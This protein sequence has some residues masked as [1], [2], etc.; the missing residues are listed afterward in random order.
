[1]NRWTNVRR[2][3]RVDLEALK[4]AHPIQEVLAAYGVALRQ[5]GRAAVGRCP[6]HADQGRPN[7]YAWGDTASWFCFRCALGGDVVRFVELAEGLSFRDAVDRLAAGARAWGRF[8]P[9][10]QAHPPVPPAK[11]AAAGRIDHD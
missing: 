11:Q 5:Q 2:A 6:F 7:L 4:Q 8:V 10:A 1:M 3:A 9:S